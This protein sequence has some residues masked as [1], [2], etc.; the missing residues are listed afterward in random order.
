M[1]VCVSTRNVSATENNTGG[2]IWVAVCIYICVRQSYCKHLTSHSNITF[3]HKRERGVCKRW[4]GLLGWWNSGMVGWKFLG[5]HFQ[6]WDTGS[7][8]AGMF[9]LLSAF[10]WL[11]YTGLTIVV[12]LVMLVSTQ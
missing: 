1:L 9:T 2:G 4:D 6:K 3:S 5:V 11:V 7:W 12:Y 8:G 10:L